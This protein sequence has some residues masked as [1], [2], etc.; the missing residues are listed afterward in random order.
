MPNVY[1]DANVFLVY[2]FPKN[3][4]D[5][6]TAIAKAGLESNNVMKCPVLAADLPMAATLFAEKYPDL[7]IAGVVNLDEM[8]K[9]IAF[10]EQFKKDNEAA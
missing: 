7:M 9:E 5:D 2:G 10:M 8:K 1:S 6:P 3:G 4:M